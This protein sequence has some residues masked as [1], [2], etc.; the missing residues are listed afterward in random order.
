MPRRQTFDFARRIYILGMAVIAWDTFL[1]IEVSGFHIKLA[2]LLLLLATLIAFFHP[3][4][5]VDHEEAAANRFGVFFAPL[6]RKPWILWGFFTLLCFA[7]TPLSPV[8]RKSLGYSCWAAFNLTAY[9]GAGLRLFVYGGR[10][11]ELWRRRLL[12]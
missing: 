12:N 2:Y 11:C 10:D 8:A 1:T 6:L 7:L 5:P 4:D 3:A 9:V